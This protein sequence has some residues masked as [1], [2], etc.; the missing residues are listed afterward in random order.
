MI[1]KGGMPMYPAI[2]FAGV[3][4]FAWAMAIFA[5]YLDDKPAALDR[6]SDTKESKAA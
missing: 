3:T 1:E 4:A 6:S 2:A 5:S